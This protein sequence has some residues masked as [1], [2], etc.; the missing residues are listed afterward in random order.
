MIIKTPDGVEYKVKDGEEEQLVMVLRSAMFTD[1]G[2]NQAY[3]ERVVSIVGDLYGEWIN[4]DSAESFIAG[5][6]KLGILEK[7]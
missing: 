1:P 4:N 3:M 6:V 7:V 2:S 5:L